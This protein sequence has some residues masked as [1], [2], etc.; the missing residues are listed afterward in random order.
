MPSHEPPTG[1]SG[2]AAAL[3]A[4]AL[5]AMPGRAH[6]DAAGPTDFRTAVV[7]ITPTTDT[8]AVSI[9]GGD[10]FVHIEVQPGTEVVVLGYDDEPYVKIDATGTVFENLRS[11]AT[12]Y[13]VS[14]FGTD[15]I[16][17]AVDSSAEPEWSEVG[18]GGSWA[19]HDHRAHWMGTEVPVG[20]QPG[21]S[22]PAQVIPLL[23]DGERVEVEVVSTLIGGPSWVP[24]LF[25]GLFGAAVTQCVGHV[26]PHR[27]LPGRGR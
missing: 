13:N 25:G 22:L 16:P 14:R 8:V 24:T 9:A 10:S 20:M 5:V 11:Y 6:A 27:G 19:W 15:D 4:L 12:Y 18:G 21:D 3:V 1:S 2:R 26:G 23:V 7:S 17:D